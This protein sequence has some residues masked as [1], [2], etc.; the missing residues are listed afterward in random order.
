MEQ[1][2][3]RMNEYFEERIAS[4]VLRSQELLAEERTDEASFEKIRAN[5]YDIF[6]TILSVAVKTGRGDAAA[7]R[8]FF[9]E[10]AAEIPSS[11]EAAYEKASQHQDA[12]KMQI[13]RIKL[14]TIEEIRE[15]FA[16]NWEGES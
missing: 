1:K 13:E 14:D 5:V 12:V 8:R 9:T 7:V 2:V 3:S 11:W 10:K 4:C 15:R 6:K 16:R